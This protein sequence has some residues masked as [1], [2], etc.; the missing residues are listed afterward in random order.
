MAGVSIGTGAV[1]AAGAVVTRDISPYQVA[2]GV[3]ARPLRMRFAPEIVDKLMTIAWWN[4]DRLT[5]EQGFGYF[6]NIE[7]FIETYG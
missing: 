1:V 7:R 5:L 4:W 2:A 6:S 3:P